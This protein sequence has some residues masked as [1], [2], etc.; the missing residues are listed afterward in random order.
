M[1]VLVTFVLPDGWQRAPR[2]K[3]VWQ[4]ELGLLAWL[5]LVL[6]IAEVIR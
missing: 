2:S 4:E 6:A 1:P 5:L 3:L